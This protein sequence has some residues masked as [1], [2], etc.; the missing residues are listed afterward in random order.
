MLLAEEC[1]FESFYPGTWRDG[2]MELFV[3]C[4]QRR[5]DS[6]NIAVG[7]QDGAVLKPLHSLRPALL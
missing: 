2:P 6:K 3:A 5:C 7:I 1:Y 4:L